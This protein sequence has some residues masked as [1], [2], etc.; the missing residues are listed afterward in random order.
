MPIASAPPAPSPVVSNRAARRVAPITAVVA[1]VTTALWW[2]VAE[3]L[4]L[5]GGRWTWAL[6]LV[7]S[8]AATESAQLHVEF[9]RQT[10]SLSL[11]EIPL[12]LGLFLVGPVPL[13]LCTL[14]GTLL[15]AG[16]RRTA[17]YRVWF[18]VLIFTSHVA[19]VVLL[20]HALAGLRPRTGPQVWVAS[21][22]AVLV[23][24]LIT[25]ATVLIAIVRVQ[26]RMNRAD[27]TSSYW[28][29]LVSTGFNCSVA[30]LARQ[31]SVQDPRALPILV[32]LGLTL[33]V[34]YRA[35]SRL[36]QRHKT[37]GLMRQFTAA[38]SAT[39]GTTAL[40]AQALTHVR[41][42]LSADYAELALDTTMSVPGSRGDGAPIV[43]ASSGSHQLSAEPPPRDELVASALA[44]D[45]CLL[46]SRNTRD[47]ASRNWLF[48]RG[49]R[50]AAA[51]AL[52]SEDGPLGYLLVGDRLGETDS[53]Q[54]VDLQLLELVAAHLSVALR[55]GELVDRL[56]YDAGHDALTGLP[57]RV[58]FRSR[59]H[60]SLQDSAGSRVAVL[61]M[62]LDE[63]K[64]VND[65]LGHD[66]GDALLREVGV[67][68]RRVMPEPVTVAR[69]GGDEFAAL[70]PLAG[71]SPDEVLDIA[72][73]LQSAL[74]DP[75][76]LAGVAVGVRASV[77]V[78]VYPDH[79]GDAD[80]LLQHA[81]G[82][83][84]AGKAARA[85]VQVYNAELDRSNPRR[86]ALVSELR[87]AIEAGEI[88][89]HYQP[90][91][92]LDS[93]KIIGVEALA[94]WNHPRL[95]LV[96]PDDFIPIA[97]HTGQITALTSHVLTI[98]LTQCAA[99]LTAGRELG[100][101]VN[102]SP[103][104]LLT[105]GFVAE[106]RA[107]L[108]A[109]G[110]PPRLLTLEITESGVMSEPDLAQLVLQELHELGV[111]LSIDDFGTGYSS[112][113]YLLHLPVD[114]VKID[115]SF[116]LTLATSPRNTSM[117]QAIIELGHTLGLR[118]VAEGVEDL[119]SQEMLTSLQCDVAQGYLI[120]RP[121]PAHVLDQWLTQAPVTPRRTSGTDALRRHLSA[122]PSAGDP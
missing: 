93:Q 7:V 43:T 8:F 118:V 53:F 29:V 115:K 73:S 34:G 4:P 23:A 120:S 78:A 84:Y 58:L 17:L 20:F 15:I 46:I 31:V 9:R 105:P 81:D 49:L 71:T 61:L 51:V 26:G 28:L 107:A 114:E 89:C 91:V 42:V 110:V 19:M 2:W 79:A 10:L 54:R 11:S 87:Q 56:R 111:A 55:N 68:L 116:V 40:T 112:L 44:T 32:V 45:S 5:W 83:M 57:N 66:T 77:G 36:L 99:W 85:A 37:L 24:A 76:E 67:R 59:L 47:T 98:S 90:K 92:S 101:A 119:R 14:A 122:A 86:L 106:V 50:D 75:F 69:L 48:R 12:V 100:V 74:R 102:V 60:Q 103:R 13:L 25:G 80:L 30:L 121:V 70:T 62:D 3:T 82:A 109:V 104:G 64:D 18:N 63:F 72:A 41:A 16:R 108:R 6:A 96:P 22:V 1:L 65:T 95:G 117:V 39:E 97:E 94:R 21:Y 27:I 33:G 35:Y 38:V 113:A 88:V 52:H